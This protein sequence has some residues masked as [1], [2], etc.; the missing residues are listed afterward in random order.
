MEQPAASSPA[1]EPWP[2]SVVIFDLDGTLYEQRPLRRAMAARLARTYVLR[3]V[4]GYRVLRI[5]A[6]YRRAQEDLRGAALSDD[7]AR[8]QVELAAKTS[9]AD[10][11]TVEI[12]VDRWMTTVPLELLARFARPGVGTAL[13]TLR[14][15]GLRL[16]VLSDYPAAS[17]LDALGLSDRFDLV[18]S[19]DDPGIGTFKPDPRGLEVVLARL[20][21][22]G[23][24]AVYVGDRLDVDAVAAR[25]AGVRCVIVNASDDGDPGSPAVRFVPTFEALTDLLEPAR[26]R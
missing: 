18:A 22:E 17:K 10:P 5:L 12:V 19:S 15:R 24:E 6:A 3:P 4:R 16:A 8:A 11:G 26:G 14:S 25:A 13:T 23:H 1:R 7:L 2:V 21:V 9:G 20:G